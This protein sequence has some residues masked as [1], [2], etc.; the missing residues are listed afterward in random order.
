MIIV[1]PFP[2]SRPSIGGTLCDH[3]T[4]YR[5]PKILKDLVASYADAEVNRSTLLREMYALTLWQELGYI[6]V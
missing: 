5:F 3:E 2:P 4:W 1:R 6:V